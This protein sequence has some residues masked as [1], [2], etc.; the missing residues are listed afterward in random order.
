MH[1]MVKM[2]KWLKHHRIL[3]CIWF[4]LASYEHLWSVSFH[5]LG[6]WCVN[7]CHNVR[8]LGKKSH[9]R[10]K[11][12]YWVVGIFVP[13][14][15]TA[16]KAEVKIWSH[17]RRPGII[18]LVMC[19]QFKRQHLWWTVYTGFAATWHLFLWRPCLFQQGN[20]DRRDRQILQ[21]IYL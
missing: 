10:E 11:K 14:G 3:T 18:Q 21:S 6:I 9:P 16:L 20:A 15:G 1:T 13:S 5:Q 19:K 7:V 17:G 8:Y 2:I 4:S 12:Q